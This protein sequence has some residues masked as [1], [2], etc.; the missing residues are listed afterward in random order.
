M[1]CIRPNKTGGVNSPINSARS[2]VAVIAAE[3]ACLRFKKIE[4]KNNSKKQKNK[5]IK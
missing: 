1:T 3:I 2:V 5:K 4:K